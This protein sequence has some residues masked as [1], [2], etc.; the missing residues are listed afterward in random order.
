MRWSLTAPFLLSLL[1]FHGSVSAQSAAPPADPPPVRIGPLLLTGYVQF[2]YLGT[3]DEPP[4]DEPPLQDDETE[5]RDFRLRR[6]RFQLAGPLTTGVKWAVSAEATSQPVL[7][8]AYVILDFLPAATIRA[9]QFV[10]PYS[11]ERFVASSNTMEFTE[12]IL[13]DLAPGRD[14]GVMVSNERPFFGWL[15]YGAGITNGTGQNTRDDNRAKDAMVRLS[16]APQRLPG[17]QLA[18]NIAGGHQ[19]EGMRTRVGGD[20]RFENRLY[21]V[22]GEFLRERTQDGKAEQDGFYAFGSWRFY[23]QVQRRGFHHLELAVRYARLS[24][25][26]TDVRQWDLAVNYYVHRTLRFM[27]DVIV[28]DGRDALYDGTILH[29]RANFRF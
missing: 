26:V 10:M 21:H 28:P 9:G 23:P 2:D 3:G 19:P 6:V 8:D 29:T 4:F 11:H 16:A 12:R 13:V 7:R 5:P 25:D 27:C 1:C 15:S 20:V 18:V 14:A 17:L 22:G 24:G